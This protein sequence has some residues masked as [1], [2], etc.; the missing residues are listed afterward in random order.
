MSPLARCVRWTGILALTAAAASCGGDSG[1][2]PGTPEPSPSATEQ[3]AATD[4][5]TP[6]ASTSASEPSTSESPTSAPEPSTPELSAP[7]PSTAESATS[8]PEPSTPELSTSEPSSPESPTAAGDLAFDIGEDTTLREVFDAFSDSERACIRDALKDEL[9]SVLG[10]PVLSEDNDESIASVLSCLA[11]ETGREF[12][13]STIMAGFEAGLEAEGLSTEIGMDETACM[14]EFLAGIDVTSMA[15]S[16]V[17][18]SGNPGLLGMLDCIPDLLIE[19]MLAEVGVE[20]DELTEEER[21]CL[22]DVMADADWAAFATAP[23]SDESALSELVFEL[24]VCALE[25][26]SPPPADIA[27]SLREATP[28]TVGV[29]AP[30]EIERDGDID[31]FVFEADAGELYQIDVTLETLSDS[32]ATLYDSDGFEL[33]YNDDHGDTYAS[34]IYWEAQSSANLYVA[35]EGWSG[36][37]SYTLTV[38]VVDITD[39]HASSREGATQVTVGKA[40]PGEIERDGDIDFFVFEADAGVLY[41]IDV[42]LETLSDS[43]ATLYDSDGFELEYNDDHGDTYASRIYWEAQSSANLYVAVEGWSGTGS[44]TLTIVTP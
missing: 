3:P 41:Q 44:Y 22:R 33:E 40:A 17:S 26:L 25:A 2:A 20:M 5:A 16:F 35:V 30:G 9:E 28:V 31:F 42:T 38:A 24:M 7:E 6:A 27:G 12:L 23:D 19:S 13:L 39:D 8:A 4:T 32:V 36:T 11:P 21:A 15:N 14:R 10:M 43:V 29:L 34:R 18:E 37:G 1:P